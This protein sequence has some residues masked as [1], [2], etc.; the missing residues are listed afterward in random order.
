MPN[1][2]CLADYVTSDEMVDSFA[3]VACSAGRTC[4][5]HG[6][7]RPGC[8]QRPAVL[9]LGFHQETAAKFLPRLRDALREIEERAAT[10][11]V[12]IRYDRTRDAARFVGAAPVFAP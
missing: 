5:Q 9:S 6:M 4:M 3:A 1:N 7:Q 10:Q 12:P 8:M 11:R 2:G